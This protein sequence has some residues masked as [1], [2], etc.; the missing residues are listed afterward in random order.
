MIKIKRL[1][2]IKMKNKLLLLLIFFI[3]GFISCS[4]DDTASYDS[5]NS[6]YSDLKCIK[7]VS[8]TDANSLFFYG[9]EL[10]SVR[11][12]QVLKK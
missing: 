4:N 3:F 1:L 5:K 7:Y 11:F 6:D 12:L 9:D 2:E 10:K 8:I